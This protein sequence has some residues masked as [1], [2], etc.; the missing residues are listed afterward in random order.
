M[1]R[2]RAAAAKMATAITSRKEANSDRVLANIPALK[3]D[4]V[5]KPTISPPLSTAWKARR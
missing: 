2:D 5:T 1:P 4:T 3:M